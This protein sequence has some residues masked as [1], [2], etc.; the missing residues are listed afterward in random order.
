MIYELIL[1]P[2]NQSGL[3]LDKFVDFG[4]GGASVMT[5]I[6]NEV[7]ARLKYKVNPFILSIHC[8]A[9][10]TYFVSLDATKCTLQKFV[11]FA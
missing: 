4:Y 3:N 8:V 1:T 5:G 6:R 11:Y 9:H 10:G 7:A 2:L